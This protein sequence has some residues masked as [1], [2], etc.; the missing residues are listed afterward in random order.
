MVNA[1]SVDVEEYFH[2]KVFQEGTNGA[3]TGLVGFVAGLARQTVARNVTINNLLPGIFDS[4]AQKRH[5]QAILGDFEK[6]FEQVWQERAANSPA[7]RYGHPAEFGAYFAFLCSAQAG[8]INGQNLLIDGGSYPG[9][10]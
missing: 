10:F 8:Y 5:I 3:R 1:L 7:R 2:A 6:T 9:T 4:D